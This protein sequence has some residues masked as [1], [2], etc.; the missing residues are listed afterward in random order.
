MIALPSIPSATAQ[1]QELYVMCPQYPKV[2][3][4]KNLLI[5]SGM[6]VFMMIP[7]IVTNITQLAIEI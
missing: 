1:T 7:L 3:N 6:L 2:R 5:S 4:P